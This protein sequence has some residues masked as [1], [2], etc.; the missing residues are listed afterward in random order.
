MALNLRKSWS[1]TAPE[2]LDVPFKTRADGN[3]DRISQPGNV[4]AAP[5]AMSFFNA[6]TL[7]DKQRIMMNGGATNTFEGTAPRTLIYNA[8]LNEW[9]A[10]TYGRTVQPL[11]RKRKQHTVTI[12]AH[13][14]AWLWGGTSDNT[15]SLGPTIY[16]NS[17]V[18]LDTN[19]WAYSYPVA[20][21]AAPLP[22]IDHSATLISEN[23]ILI[24]GGMIYSRNAT[25]PYGK[26]I[27][28]AVSMGS[29]LLYDTTAG[30]WSNVSAG[31]NI[32]APRRGHSAILSSDGMRVI[33]F[34]GGR[35]VL[36]SAEAF[37]DVFTL[38]LDT[39][40]W[41][42]P[43]LIGVP[44]SPRKYHEAHLMDNL[45]LIVFGM[46]S[47]EKGNT[48]TGILN[49]STGSWISEY[50]PYTPGS[51]GGV[52]ANPINDQTAPSNT[53]GISSIEYSSIRVLHIGSYSCLAAVLH[54][55]ESISI[56]EEDLARKTA[57]AA[58]WTQSPMDTLNMYCIARPKLLPF[59]SP[60]LFNSRKMNIINQMSRV[61]HKNLKRRRKR[62]EIV[63]VDYLFFF[64]L[65][66]F[67]TS[68]TFLFICY[69]LAL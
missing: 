23:E 32:P 14:R 39:M 66:F 36:E 25:D 16:Y 17:W 6:V 11:G 27:L 34:G 8:K 44:P 18:L 42:A 37:N 68:F 54:F 4:L 51:S 13:G 58:H 53:Y 20:Q 52:E 31:G 50:T 10:P 48:D 19:T 30:R 49:L 12:D 43:F 41:T 3:I 64:F 56:E 65:S 7:P 67:F 63:Q 21:N 55:L 15:T 26:F 60:S 24:M 47:D 62:N 59:H 38:E 46:G 35:P 40:S 28:N 33:L 9:S 5:F 57:V 22:R 61:F 45:M 2:W 29:L 69:F 1:I